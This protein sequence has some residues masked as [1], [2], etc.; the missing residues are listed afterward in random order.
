MKNTNSVNFIKI[1]MHGMTQI[2]EIAVQIKHK[3]S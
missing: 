3:P 2:V 1:F